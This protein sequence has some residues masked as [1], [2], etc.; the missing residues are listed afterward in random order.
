MAVAGGDSRSGVV[1]GSSGRARIVALDVIRGF[2]LC[3]VLLAN[4][5]P[6][7]GSL[8]VAVAGA[9]D[10]GAGYA[11]LF[12]RRRFFPIFS[13]LFGIG[14][15]LLLESAEGRVDRPSR[16]MLR[17]LLVLFGFGGAHLLVWSGDVLAMYALLGLLILMPSAAMPRW[18]AAGASGVLVVTALVVGD[19][20]M[21]LAAGLFLLGA[22]LTRYGVVARLDG[23]ARVPAVAGALL[24]VVAV[25]VLWV[26]AT[27]QAGGWWFNFAFSAAGLLLAGVY[28]CV[29][30]VL[31]RTPLG[32][33][34][35][36]VFVPLGRMALTNYLTAT[37]LILGVA[38]V[39]R[40]SSVALEPG[41][42]VSIAFAVLAV[43]WAWSVLWLRGRR[44]GPL[45][46]LW[47]RAT[48]LRDF[49]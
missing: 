36:C 2:A 21:I 17:R 6:I 47:R 8:G 25:P 19:N 48:W 16:P 35:Q 38:V 24:G 28:V 5:A 12:V 41:P 18:A 9:S 31:L 20:G 33:V 1:P 39:L 37:F 27:A 11:E 22:A 49:R 26:Q 29:L 44:H 34:L 10:A 43:Q 40:D 13:V 3:G 7:A 30:L 15:A 45:E 4:A 14:F 42:A 46:W 23:A 32:P